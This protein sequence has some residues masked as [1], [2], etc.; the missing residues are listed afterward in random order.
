[1]KQTLTRSLV[2]EL[3]MPLSYCLRAKVQRF[4]LFSALDYRRLNLIQKVYMGSRDEGRARDAIKQLENEGID[5][6]RV[7]WLNLDLSD[8][9]L[10]RRTGQEILDKEQRL[11][12]LGMYQSHQALYN[13]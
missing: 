11:D 5:A 13:G 7:H 4:A 9:R 8:P 12:I 1:M 6:G 2:P 10:A 3:V